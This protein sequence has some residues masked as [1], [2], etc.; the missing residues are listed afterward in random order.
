MTTAVD[1][2]GRQI[3]LKRSPK[4]IVCL[5]AAGLDILIELG[6][7]P[8]GYLSKGVAGN[9]D[10]YG[11]RAKKFAGVGS[12]MF[13]DCRAIKNLQPDLIIGWTFPHRFYGGKLNRL[14]ATY[15]MG[16]NGYQGS[17]RRLR[18]IARLTGRLSKAERKVAC[19]QERLT[20]Y[21]SSI[22]QHKYKTVLFMGGSNLNYIS[23]QFIV[24]TNAGT[25]GS[26]VEQFTNYPWPE[27]PRN[28][29]P[30]LTSISLEKILAVNPDII[31][32]QTYPPA[33]TPLSEQLKGDCLWQQLTAVQSQNVY[34]IEQLWHYGN[35]THM[36]NLTLDKLMPFIYPEL[37]GKLKLKAV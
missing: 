10:F 20:R 1:F 6:L 23:R 9:K 18:D 13:P 14:A 37:F 21:Y 24:E 11:D 2:T 12:W 3:E 4:R 35:G 15:L 19:L 17:L 16:G 33:K 27:P 31:F 26:I 34:E 28:R 29:E 22:P 25:M 32:V 8:V 36:I 7:E 5:S 30:G